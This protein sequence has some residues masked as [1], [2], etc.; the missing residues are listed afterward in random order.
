M[1]EEPENL[2]HFL[3]ILDLV[4]EIVAVLTVAGVEG[5]GEPGQEEHGGVVRVLDNRRRI[6][7]RI[8]AFDQ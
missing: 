4:P 1:V 8:A 2:P 6:H 5:M 7:L 3:K